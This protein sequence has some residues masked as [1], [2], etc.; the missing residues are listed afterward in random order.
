MSSALER[1]TT[2]GIIQTGRV[3]GSLGVK[4]GE[5][6]DMFISLFKGE[7]FEYRI[8]PAIDGILPR[9]PLECDAWVITGSKHAVYEP[10]DWISPLE[11]FVRKLIV[12]G[13]PAVGICFGHQLMAQAMGGKVEKFPGGWNI[14]RMTLL[15]L[16]N[17]QEARLH[18]THMDQVME[19]PPNA[20]LILTADNCL[21]GG[22]KYSPTCL[23]IQAH[24]ELTLPFMVD[25]I[26]Q[27]RGVQLTTEHADD[28]LASL[29]GPNDY[30][31]YGQWIADI[32]KGERRI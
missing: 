17:K 27:R 21:F 10:H 15:D 29:A 5:Y 19:P 31:I 24:P 1:K 16:L 25:L 23:S 32:L 13:Q 3:G 26:N 6:P 2:V 30:D 22:F 18:F 7:P 28:A 12:S 8:Y 4:Y 20:E 11:A 14:G 9:H